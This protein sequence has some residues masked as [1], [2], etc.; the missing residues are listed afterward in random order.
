MTKE[1]VV[2]TTTGSVGDLKPSNNLNSKPIF[3]VIIEEGAK[4]RSLTSYLAMKIEKHDPYV[5]F[6]GHVYDGQLVG[7]DP[8]SVF[9][10]SKTEEITVPWCRVAQIK[11]L[12]Y[13]SLK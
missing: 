7:I 13:K 10:L 11:N 6:K 3:L 5:E 9:D 12:S 1:D 4:N 8:H 2:L